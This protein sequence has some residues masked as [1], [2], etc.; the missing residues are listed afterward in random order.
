MRE[1]LLKAG[2]ESGSD[3][4]A[5]VTTGPSGYQIKGATTIDLK[6]AKALHDRDVPFVDVYRRWPQGHIPSAYFRELWT[7]EFNE[8]R[9]S[10]IVY[11]TDEVVI[12]SSGGDGGGVHRSAADACAQALIWGFQKAY[13]FAEGLPGWKAAGYPVEKSG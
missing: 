9:L 8:V 12:Y 10:E 3:W 7:G 11:K 2:V 13:C 4:A 6:T 1:G 5:L